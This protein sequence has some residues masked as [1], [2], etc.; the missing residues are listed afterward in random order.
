MA[1]PR[2][3]AFVNRRNGAP[4][5]RTVGPCVC[6][7][8]KLWESLDHAKDLVQST[9]NRMEEVTART[10]CMAAAW[11][12]GNSEVQ[13]QLSMKCACVTP[14]CWRPWC[15]S[16]HTPM[17]AATDVASPSGAP[18]LLW[19]GPDMCPQNDAARVKRASPSVQHVAKLGGQPRCIN[20]A[21]TG[22]RGRALK[23]F[24]KSNTKPESVESV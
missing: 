24:T 2:S 9:D 18:V 14:K 10:S 5:G 20:R 12:S 23:N 8:S 1:V 16:Q 11:A 22:C 6:H 3:L 15:K 19:C 7:H 4:G 21:L 13:A 17:A